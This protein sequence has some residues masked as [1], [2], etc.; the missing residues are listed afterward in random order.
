[1]NEMQCDEDKIEYIQGK[2]QALP[3]LK[4]CHRDGKHQ[5]PLTMKQNEL[6]Q[7]VW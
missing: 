3:P 4:S 5:V 6:H 7:G 2:T 1:M